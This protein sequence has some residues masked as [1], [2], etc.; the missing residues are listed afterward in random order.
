MPASEGK[1]LQEKSQKTLS[2]IRDCLEDNK[3]FDIIE[4]DLKGKT[5]EADFMLTARTEMTDKLEGFKNGA[6]DYL[7]KPFEP[8]E[9]LV[10]IRAI[11]RRNQLTVSEKQTK[12]LTDQG[13]NLDFN[14][15]ILNVNGNKINLTANE[16]A[17]LHVFDVHKNK[18][19]SREKIVKE[20][21]SKKELSVSNKKIINNR[22]IDLQITRLRK[23]IEPNPTHPTFLKTVRGL[24]YKLFIENTLS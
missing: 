19:L 16:M 20:L 21:N 9:L 22:L 7:T 23:K 3:A 15:Q 11:V 12:A 13:F 6:D 1:E 4:I 24:G 17:L 8:E 18:V 14:K 10:R 2:T 5:E